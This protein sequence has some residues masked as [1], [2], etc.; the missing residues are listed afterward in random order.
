MA[1]YQGRF[2]SLYLFCDL[3]HCMC[4]CLLACARVT[5]CFV[6]FCR[7]YEFKDILESEVIDIEKLRKVTFRGRWVLQLFLV[8]VI[9]CSFC[10]DVIAVK[11]KLR[12]SVWSRRTLVTGFCSVCRL[13]SSG[14]RSL[15]KKIITL[16]LLAIL[17][18]VGALFTTVSSIRVSRV[19]GLGLPLL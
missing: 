14:D 15:V 17:Q 11:Y 6:C 18:E 16:V 7:L 13:L 10:R 12:M 3:I 2:V 5:R 1:S 8:W 9:I 19:V 4:K